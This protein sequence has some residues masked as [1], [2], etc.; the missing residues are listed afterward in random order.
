MRFRKLHLLCN[1]AASQ[2]AFYAGLLGLPLVH[3]YETGFCVQAGHTLLEFSQ[4]RNLKDTPYHIAFNVTPQLLPDVVPFLSDKGVTLIP[5]DGAA[6]VDFPNW[7]ARS[8]YFYDAEQNIM[9]CIARY[10]LQQDTHDTHFS[11]KHMLCVSEVGV[12]VDD[13]AA[14]IQTLQSHTT[15]DVW[16]DY[17]DQFK[18]AGDEEGLLIVV[19]KGRHWFP[20]NHP[21]SILPIR[22][23][24]AQE[25]RLFHYNGH[26]YTFGFE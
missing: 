4:T 7:N 14:F 26:S 18:A 11:A 1:N 20:T 19:S 23:E 12:P 3:S 6:V 16:K 8:V 2:Q 13:T 10:N 15:V 5:K 9:E 17:G 21:N 22:L 25:G 24:I